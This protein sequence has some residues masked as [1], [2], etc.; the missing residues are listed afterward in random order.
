MKNYKRYTKEELEKWVKESVSLSDVLRKKGVKPLGS[1]FRVLKAALDRFEI[2]YSHFSGQGWSKD[3]ILVKLDGAKRIE[4]VKKIILNE[5][6]HS[7]E[8][9]NNIEWLSNK[10]P[11]EL[12][13]ID[14]NYLNNSRENLQ[15]LCCNCHALTDGWRKRK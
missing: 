6:G 12:H 11:L 1:S 10:I 9:C 14:G 13:H 2:D 5:R 15:L 7:C 4:T 8:L 3:K